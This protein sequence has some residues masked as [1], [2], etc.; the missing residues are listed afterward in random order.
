MV[1]SLFNREIRENLLLLFSILLIT[2][3]H[4]CTN[5]NYLLL[6]EIY[7]RLYY[8]PIIYAA[9]RRGVR[10]GVTTSIFCSFVYIPHIFLHWGHY[11]I[12]LL[13]QLAE[14]V[15]F[16]VVAVVT[17]VLANRE[18]KQRSLSEQ[19]AI[20]LQQAYTEL[21]QTVEQL[22]VAERMASLAE[23]SLA[24]VHEVRNPLG[25]IRGA[26]EALETVILPN[27]SHAE[28]LNI[29]QAEVNRLNRL[30]T[31]FLEF[32]RPRA[33]EKLPTPP[34]ELIQSVILLTNK[35]I[36]KYNVTINT[37]LASDLPTIFVDSEQIK[38]VLINLALNALDAMP[39]GGELCFSTS[40]QDGKI[41]IRITDTGQGLS[42]EIQEQLFKPFITT[43][44]TGSGLGLA[45]CY[46]LVTQNGGTICVEKK[47]NSGTVFL[48]RFPV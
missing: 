39:D 12:Y 19:S 15:L 20:E 11:E 23:L 30:V 35:Q 46:K 8:I 2:A 34:N 3:L 44:A 1:R 37:D 4:F 32:G 24:L 47:N 41:V 14:V 25:A 26:A 16:Q 22:V 28:F 5:T 9:Y 13:N 40:L 29:I 6:H 27:N 38:Q 18:R 48:L 17:G 33:P 10:G 43:K 45:I 42:E 31:D 36:K 21:Q 7:Q